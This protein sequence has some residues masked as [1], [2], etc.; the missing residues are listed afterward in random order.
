MKETKEALKREFRHHLT[1]T[2]GKR[3]E[4]ANEL[5]RYQA[6][7]LSI[8]DLMIERWIATRETFEED[9]PRFV[10]YISLEYL[11]GRTLGNAMI[12]LGVFDTA[13]QA[14]NEMGY[15]LE[16]IREQEV[17]AGLG[18]GGLGRL[19]AC[20]LDSL[21]TMNLPAM[22]YGIRY[23]YG[24]FTQKI[25]NGYQVEEPDNW[26]RR[27]NPWEIRRPE[28]HRVVHFHGCTENVPGDKNPLRRRWVDTQ[29][30]MAMPYDTP[31]PG[32][33]TNNVNT[34]RLW[35]AESLYGFDLGSFNKGDYLDANIEASMTENITKVLY[36]NDNNYEGKELRLKQQYFLVSATMQ[37]I[38]GR[39]DYDGGD[40]HKFHE[41][42]VVQLN[43]THPAMAIPELMRLLVDEK[44]LGWDEAWNI[45]AH[46]FNYTN[47]TLMSE[48]LERWPVDMM[49]KLIP[50][51]LEIIYEINFRF[52][53]KIST[54]FPGNTDLLQRMSLIEEGPQK[55]VRMAYMAVVA[56][57]H[58]NGVAALHTELLKHGL[59]KDF[60]DFYPDKFVNVT[61]GITPRRWL[62]KAN[63][64]LSAVI[65]KKIGE[66]WVKDLDELK[67]LESMASNKT[68]QKQVADAKRKN[69]VHLAEIIQNN[70]GVTIDPDSL[71][72]VQVKRLHEYKRQLLNILHAIAMYLELKD[73]PDMEF[74]PRTIMFAAKAAPGYYLAKMIIKLINSVADV[75]N[76]DDQVK[77]KLKILFLPNYRVSLAEKIIPAA[78]LSEQI[79]LAGT[80]A[81][82]TGNMKFSLNGALT[83]GTMDGANIEIHDA[84][85]ADNIFIFGMSVAEVKTLREQGYHPWDFINQNPLLKRVLGLI[86]INFFSQA[87]PG[88]F[89]P[90]L[91]C[92][93]NDFYM[94]AADFHSYY[95]TQKKVSELYRS[96]GEWT[97]KAIVNIANMGRFSSDRS[98]RDYAKKIWK[99]KPVSVKDPEFSKAIAGG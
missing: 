72:D 93:N 33:Q 95:E 91:D 79:S 97:E 84:V 82:G 78:D 40:I 99:L 73:N 11:I 53:R 7:A 50:R 25:E 71:F 98:I 47:H 51:I 20:F 12:N 41:R 6:M 22:G 92:L 86:K 58:V 17:D 36:P 44:G 46:T 64:E 70:M 52:L 60:C 2:L 45:C 3:P 8:R 4:K 48:A 94:C 5:D 10:S 18:N 59:F 80:E 26:L 38:I 85:G 74:T 29:D 65:S 13:K 96:K 34:L 76:T 42:N 56:S 49:Q 89:Q 68:F 9:K 15:D 1:L 63:P 81:S 88:I 54:R 21:A 28:L 39:L 57:E 66:N 83:I 90:I 69:K 37:D 67:Q 30:V 77:D 75:V 27:G 55:M 16:D 32:Y 24:I 61:N 14:M 23:D 62:R 43:D 31:I 19:A 87:E 35:S